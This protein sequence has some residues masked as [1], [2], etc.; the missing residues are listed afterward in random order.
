MNRSRGLTCNQR[1]R[2][3]G[4]DHGQ[5][6][7]GPVWTAVSGPLLRHTPAGD[8]W[9]PRA[10]TGTALSYFR[11]FAAVCTCSLETDKICRGPFFNSGKSSKFFQEIII[12][13]WLLWLPH[14]LPRDLVYKINGFHCTLSKINSL[15]KYLSNTYLV[16]I[17]HVW[18]INQRKETQLFMS[19]PQVSGL[20]C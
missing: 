16:R 17:N 1:A 14:L 13:S 18:R 8:T 7:R 9:P 15:T 4:W 10:I 2:L 11:L 6:M 3:N 12:I 19:E 5:P 20:L